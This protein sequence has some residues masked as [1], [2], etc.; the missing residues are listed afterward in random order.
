MSLSASA[1]PAAPPSA[2]PSALAGAAAA[3]LTVSIWGLWV[4]S[5][6]HAVGDAL[7]AAWLGLMRYGVPA[8]VLAPFWWRGGLLPAGLDRR[9]LAVMVA[10]CGAPFFLTVSSGMASAPAAAIGVMLMGTLPFFAA[11]FS[12]A[13]DGE[14]FGRARLAGFAATL[15]ALMLIGG[16]AWLAGT[17]YGQLVFPLGAAMWAAYTLAFRRSGLPA[18]QGAGLV[19]VW[20]S[21]LLLPLALVQGPQALLAAAPGVL[22]GQFVQQGVLSGV[23]ALVAYGFA[24]RRIGPSRT[25]AFGALAPALAALFA[26]PLLGEWPD[27]RLAAGVVLAV[28]GVALASGAIGAR[29]AST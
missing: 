29:R 20:S 28:A 2:A 14:R 3:L 24:V 25:A 16:P 18:L 6:R 22:A 17:G 9:L 15:A 1:T 12:F 23:V 27:A 21:L 13:M 7:P 19:A 4:V 10:G 8:L 11:L 5:T 26:V